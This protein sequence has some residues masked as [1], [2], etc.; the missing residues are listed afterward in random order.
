M[1]DP[2]ASAIPCKFSGTE[3]RISTVASQ[4]RHAALDTTNNI[5]YFCDYSPVKERM[6]CFSTP[7]SGTTWNGK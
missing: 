3:T 5:F 2:P 4:F 1:D 6:M 7:D